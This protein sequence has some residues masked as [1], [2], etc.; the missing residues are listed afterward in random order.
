MNNNWNL[1]DFPVMKFQYNFLANFQKTYINYITLQVRL[2]VMCFLEQP[3]MIPLH[4][5]VRLY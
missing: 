5:S 1:M 2:K 4:F 3:P